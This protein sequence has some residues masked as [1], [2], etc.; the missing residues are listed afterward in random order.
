MEIPKNIK[1]TKFNSLQININQNKQI[2]NPEYT[3]HFCINKLVNIKYNRVFNFNENTA[4]SMKIQKW[5]DECILGYDKAEKML[6]TLIDYKD[7]EEIYDPEWDYQDW[8]LCYWIRFCI[9]IRHTFV[10]RKSIKYCGST[11]ARLAEGL[12]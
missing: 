6:I 7:F 4:V 3:I 1:H 10:V 9:M 8:Q 5:M 12:N 11:K 2:Q